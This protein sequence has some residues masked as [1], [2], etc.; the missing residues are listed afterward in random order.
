MFNSSFGYSQEGKAVSNDRF[1]VG[2]R[3]NAYLSCLLTSNK[4]TISLFHLFSVFYILFYFF[5]RF[6]SY[7]LQDHVEQDSVQT[8][9]CIHKQ[10]IYLNYAKKLF[11]ICW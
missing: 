10:M 8:Q 7:Q 5:L 2:I 6:Y 3:C 4:A 9:Y 1:L 11:A